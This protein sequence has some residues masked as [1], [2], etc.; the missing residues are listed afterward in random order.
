[1]KTVTLLI[2][3]LFF[4]YSLQAQMMCDPPVDAPV[5]TGASIEGCEGSPL[6]SPITVTN[7]PGE[8][9]TT[10]WSMTPSPSP[11][12]GEY[13]TN[14][15]PGVV[16]VT[17]VP[18]M[19]Y[20]RFYNVAM[21]CVSTWSSVLVMPVFFSIPKGLGNIT[22]C[23]KGPFT[24]NVGTLTPNETAQW[25]TDGFV[26]IFTGNEFG[27][28]VDP[29]NPL[30]VQLRIMNTVHGCVGPTSTYTVTAQDCGPA[31]D[32]YTS[33]VAI[34]TGI[35]GHADGDGTNASFNGP[36]GICWDSSTGSYYIADAFNHTIREVTYSGTVTTLAGTG[37]SGHANG[38]A[39]SASFYKPAGLVY[40]PA[41]SILYIA[42]RGNHQIRQLHVGT[43]TVSTLAGSGGAG[44]ED[45]TGSGAQ[46]NNPTGLVLYEGILYVT[47]HGNHAIR[48]IDISTGEVS[49]LAGNGTP[50]L[51]DGTGSEAR[52]R[53]PW[54]IALAETTLYVADYGNHAIRKLYP[55]GYVMTLAGDGTPGYADGW[56]N[57]A[58]L[59]HP[60]GIVAISNNE[61]VFTDHG[62]YSVRKLY[63]GEVTTLSGNGTPGQQTGSFSTYLNP[64][65]LATNGYEI[66]VIDAFSHTIRRLE[67]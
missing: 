8:G 29:G 30:T 53:F 28:L 27:G 48:G 13:P 10:Q 67:P 62:N 35:A 16:L 52:F 66:L 61:V 59:R 65:G 3:F 45:G 46:F 44:F 32:I 38:E 9:F 31:P 54:G 20:A 6:S 51:A 36:Q 1:M 4:S 49:T 37:A 41:T 7:F 5:F 63:E 25:S 56:G 21:N 2:Y 47:D 55:N 39:L 42:D 22:R 19:Y 57:G 23:D 12:L 15:Y 43:A 64:V 18:T 26:S 17:S 50:G 40:D 34:G 60:T 58:R 11:N 33:S 14:S 24:F